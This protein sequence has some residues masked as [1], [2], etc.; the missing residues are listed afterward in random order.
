MWR[1]F[2]AAGKPFPDLCE[3]DV[4]NYMILESVALKAAKEEKDA[5]KT[6]EQN[7]WKKDKGGLD[8]LRDK[9]FG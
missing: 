5:E 6:T 9:A 8:E 1:V 3:D 4:I 2:K 7:Q